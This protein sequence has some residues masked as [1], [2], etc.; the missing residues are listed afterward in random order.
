MIEDAERLAEIER[1][2]AAL[3][4]QKWLTYPKS[5]LAFHRQRRVRK[6]RKRRLGWPFEPTESRVVWFTGIDFAREAQP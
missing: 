5:H 1:L 6:K 4:L 2:Y 3:T